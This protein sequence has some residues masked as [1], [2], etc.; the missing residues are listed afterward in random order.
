MPWRG[1]SHATPARQLISRQLRLHTVYARFTSAGFLC[2][3]RQHLTA[4]RLSVDNV[5]SKQSIFDH[6]ERCVN[7][8]LSARGAACEDAGA[9]ARRERPFGGRCEGFTRELA[10]P[11]PSPATRVTGSS[12]R[13]GRGCCPRGRRSDSA[14]GSGSFSSS[15]SMAASAPSCCMA[16]LIS[17]KASPADSPSG[18]ACPPACRTRVSGGRP[19][20]L[21]IFRSTSRRAVA[22]SA[23][24]RV[25]DRLPDLV[26]LDAAL[27]LGGEGRLASPRLWCLDSTQARANAASSIR[28]ASVKRTRMASAARPG[29]RRGASPGQAAPG[30][31]AQRQQPQ[32]DLPRRASGS[33]ASRASASDAAASPDP[34]ARPLRVMN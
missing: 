21:A 18:P 7:R 12:R 6:H 32:A 8:T 27:Q 1:R 15:R 2:R 29:R 23:P 17:R 24:G 4:V 19:R 30:S 28:P 11:R 25:V 13:R 10:F 5:L 14:S 16:S 9:V 3:M 34:E 31:G 33:W 22:T 20:V 26:V